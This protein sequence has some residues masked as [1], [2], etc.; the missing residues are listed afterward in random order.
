MLPYC[1]MSGLDPLYLL[2]NIAAAVVKVVAGCQIPRCMHAKV[3]DAL[4]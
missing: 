4:P 1:T 2:S 3:A